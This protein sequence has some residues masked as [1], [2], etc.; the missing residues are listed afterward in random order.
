M[1]A[2]IVN[3]GSVAD[4]IAGGSTFLAVLVALF[5]EPIAAWLNRPRLRVRVLAGAPDV[6]K[7]TMHVRLPGPVPTFGTVPIYMFRLWI[8]NQGR[9]RAADIQVF[10]SSLESTNDG[11]LS[12]MKVDGFL[13]MNLLWSHAIKEPE[14]FAEGI[15][16]TM[17][18]HCDL[19]YVAH[20][21]A[22]AALG[23]ELPSVGL[24]MAVFCLSLE[25]APNTKSHLIPPGDYRLTLRIAG[26]NCEAIEETLRIKL[27]GMWSEN[28]VHMLAENARV[29]TMGQAQ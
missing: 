4:W 12:F 27:T 7:T 29:W 11:G 16:P 2:E 25:T 6:A 24:D 9:S 20:P 19:G 3:W 28:E 10:A 14:V 23:H 22:R 13:P 21:P 17:G 8:E 5:R 1:S 26:S 15:A 18:K